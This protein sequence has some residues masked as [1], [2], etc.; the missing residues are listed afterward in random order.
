M[1]WEGVLGPITVSHLE[2]MC[3]VLASTEVDRTISPNDAMFVG[4]LNHYFS[5]GLSGLV[6]IRQALAASG[7]EAGNVQTILD[8]PCGHGRVLRHVRSAFPQ[9]EITACDL[10]RDGVDFCAARFG[11]IPEY[12]DPDPSRIALPRDRFDLIWVGSLL[13][14]F[15]APRWVTFFELFR[16]V[17]KPGG[18]LVFSTHGRRAHEWLTTGRYSYGLDGP[19]RDQVVR[20][21]ESIGFGYVDYPNEE[22]YGI[23]IS[24]LSWVCRLIT[25]MPEFRIVSV[26]EKAWDDHHD[27]FACVRDMGWKTYRAPAPPFPEAAAP[28]VPASLPQAPPRRR[29]FRWRRSA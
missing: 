23:A 19:P 10:D 26:A 11:A 27:V 28:E 3:E 4:D 13:T 2:R 15:D 14:H 17:L 1:E 8:F 16:S 5:D 24:E 25:S 18:V 6:C 20:S 9:A 29:L 7:Q 22:G 21:F 12:S